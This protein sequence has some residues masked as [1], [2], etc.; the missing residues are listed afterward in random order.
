MPDTFRRRLIPIRGLALWAV[1]LSTLVSGSAQ[2]KSH[3]W[4]FTE[5]FSSADGSVQFVEMLVT[6][7]AG[8][9]EWVIQ[10]ME[11]RSDANSYIFPNNLPMENTFERWLLIATPAFAEL[12]GAPTPDFEIPAGFFDPTGDTLV[13]R[14]GLDGFAI[15]PGVMPTDGVHSLERDLT[16]PVNSPTNFAGNTGSVTV[17]S[18]AIPLLPPWGALLG[19]LLLLALGWPALAR[20]GR[21]RATG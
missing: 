6:D 1:A 14:N 4:K 10:G 20:R 19:L 16:T 2:A 21:S 8:T 7:P 15:P 12:S 3:L 13:Y 18:D 17:A 11:L 5:I 9:G